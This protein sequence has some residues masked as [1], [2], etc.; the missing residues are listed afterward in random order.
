MTRI[1]ILDDHTLFRI[2]LSAVLKQDANI[3]IVGDYQ[4]FEQMKS[5]VPNMQ[6]DIVFVDI[7]LGEESGL[8]VAKYIKNVNPALKVVILS[9][10][11]EE[12]YVLNSI[13]AGVDG[14]IHK[15]VDH[16]ELLK[17]VQK[18]IK[19]EKFYSLEISNLL[20]N[21]AYNK[22]KVGLPFL[23]NK[24]KEVISYLVDGFSSKQIADKLDVSPRTIETHRANVLNKFNLKNTTDLIRK[25]IEHKIQ[26]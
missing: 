20:I 3:R 6:A 21:S 16:D 2:G 9:S 12:F 23:T 14:Y 17:G 19:G 1:V 4:N 15:D 5:L 8:D 18:I 7:T 22:S 13:E 26:L 24:E 25:I 11:R 10:H